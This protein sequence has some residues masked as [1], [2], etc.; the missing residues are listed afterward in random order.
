MTNPA[1]QTDATHGFFSLGLVGLPLG[2][3]WASSSGLLLLL[4]LLVFWGSSS[5][6]FWATGSTAGVRLATALPLLFTIFYGGGGASSSRPRGHRPRPTKV[7]GHVPRCVTASVGVSAARS[8]LLWR[9]AACAI[10]CRVAQ[11]TGSLEHPCL[12]GVIP[13]C[14]PKRAHLIAAR[15]ATCGRWSGGCLIERRRQTLR[16]PVLAC[17]LPRPLWGAYCPGRQGGCERVVANLG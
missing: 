12:A 4:L 13:C 16:F 2:F 9:G 6:G 14:C 15:S 7:S 11:G 3:F 17:R 5:S 8:S 10:Q 1:K